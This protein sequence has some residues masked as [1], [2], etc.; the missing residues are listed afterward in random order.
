M[1]HTLT[2]ECQHVFPCKEIPWETLSSDTESVGQESD[3]FHLMWGWQKLPTPASMIL[4]STSSYPDP[5]PGH[6]LLYCCPNP[7]TVSKPRSLFL[8]LHLCPQHSWPRLQSNSYQSSLPGFRPCS[9][10]SPGR[11]SSSGEAPGE[12]RRHRARAAGRVQLTLPGAAVTTAMKERCGL[13]W[14]Q[15][16]QTPVMIHDGKCALARAELGQN[17]TLTSSFHYAFVAISK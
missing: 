5:H 14:V 9:V 2:K 1:V 13:L 6:L 3:C 15:K 12:Q 11:R 4:T 7:D 8:W 16:D 10:H 17:I